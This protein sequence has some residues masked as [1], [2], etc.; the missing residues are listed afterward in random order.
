MT[1]PC[2]IRV[3]VESPCTHCEGS[4]WTRG[5]H[6]LKNG[7]LVRCGLCKGTRYVRGTR[8]LSELYDLLNSN[9]QREKSD[10]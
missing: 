4:G 8:T 2:D 6:Y 5:R 7:E 3:V 1:D 10:A 9:L